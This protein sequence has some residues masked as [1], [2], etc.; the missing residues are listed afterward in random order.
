VTRSSADSQ[1]TADSPD[2]E[3]FDD[4][5]EFAEAVGVDPT[6]Q[7]VDDYQRLVE[8]NAPGNPADPVEPP[9]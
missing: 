6:P 3:A 8:E 2:P 7:Q 9:A 5:E 4:P 1:R